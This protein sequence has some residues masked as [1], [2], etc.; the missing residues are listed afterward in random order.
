MSEER[1]QK[2][3]ASNEEAKKVEYQ[4]KIR[5]LLE[6]YQQYLEEC[7][8]VDECIDQ[9]ENM[10]SQIDYNDIADNIVFRETEH[11]KYVAVWHNSRLACIKLEADESP[12]NIN[13]ADMYER[14]FIY[15]KQMRTDVLKDFVAYIPHFLIYMTADIMQQVQK[16]SE[17]KKKIEYMLAH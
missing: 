8:T 16:L 3:I 5:R 17:T 13:L 7:K 10:L 14:E 6:S 9:L 4:T 12:D 15:M 1:I 11:Y 2:M